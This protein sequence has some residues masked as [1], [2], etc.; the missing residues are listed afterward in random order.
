M[1]IAGLGLRVYMAA[2]GWSSDD[3]LYPPQMLS[4]PQGPPFR[5]G[6]AALSLVIG[7][8]I[9]L[10]YVLLV[11]LTNWS[12]A[13]S[14]GCLLALDPF[15]IA[16]SKLVH[17]DGLL[18]SFMLISALSLISYLRENRRAY[19]ILSG[20]FAGLAFLTKSPSLFL[21]PYAMLVTT[22]HLLTDRWRVSVKSSEVHGWHR[23]IWRGVC[24]IG[25]WGLTAICVFSLLWPAI[26]A[27]PVRVLSKITQATLFRVETPHSNPDFFAGQVVV[28]DPGPLYYAAVLGWK[29]TLVTLPTVWVTVLLLL[30]RRQWGRD[31]G[32]LWCLLVYAGGFVLMMSLV[33]KKG[34]RYVLPAFPALDLLAAWGLV[35][36]ADTLGKRG[37]L[38]RQPWI[39]A[40][41][42]ATALVAQAVKVLGH[43]PY[44]GTHHNMLLGG[45][46]MAQHIL[47]LGGQGE[48]MDLA[49]RFLNDYPGAEHFTVGLQRKEEPMFRDNFLGEVQSIKHLDVDYWIFDININQR[50]R[51][52]HQWADLW[53]ACQ[54]DEPLW[55]VSF[56]GVPY[57][58]IY[59]AYP[60]RPEEFDIDHRLDMRVGDHIRLLGYRL[61]SSTIRAGDA[62]TV[63]LFWQS[64]GRLTEDYHIFVHLLSEENS[65]VA[66]HDGAPVQG[67]RPTWSWRDT[68]VLQDKHVVVTGVG[69]PGGTYTLSVGMYDHLT[70]ARLPAEE[71][72][73]ERLPEGRIVLQ[74]VQATSP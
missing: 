60:H 74:D 42:V 12:V 27:M 52:V 9:T 28:G 43:H 63:T 44:Y 68:E 21:I 48:G 61:S 36:I 33:A 62:L 2:H 53:D 7:A 71:S 1:W 30:R 65:S 38:P 69:L 55:S 45:S 4:G 56:D 37:R 72:P 64:D 17:V 34:A 57:V 5:A 54:Q 40:A 39:P 3:L 23:W 51:K 49:A 46:R 35:W 32:L 11:P 59:R 20:V 19:L 25:L 10:V 31:C 41:I 29:T 24:I 22:L 8:C 16:H 73:G 47:P 67:E 70:G 15:Y 26:W 6:V 58:W 13:F 18:A 50:K 14:G 66:Q